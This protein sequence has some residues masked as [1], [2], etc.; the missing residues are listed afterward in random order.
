[1]NYI[2]GLSGNVACHNAC[3]GAIRQ[4]DFSSAITLGDLLDFQVKRVEWCYYYATIYIMTNIGNV[5]VK[6]FAGSMESERRASYKFKV[7]AQPTTTM[8]CTIHVISDFSSDS[9]A[10]VMV[11]WYDG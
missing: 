1:M 7:V 11:E 8:T 4:F 9:C 2:P 6:E 10:A 5:N 3:H